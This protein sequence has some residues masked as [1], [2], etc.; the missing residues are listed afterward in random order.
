MD[1]GMGGMAETERERE[2]QCGFY[3]QSVLFDLFLL[4]EI[5]LWMMMMMG[6]KAE[7]SFA[8]T[9][10][11]NGFVVVG[12]SLFLVEGGLKQNGF[13]KGWVYAGGGVEW[14]AE[15]RKIS[16]QVV[17]NIDIF[18]S[19]YEWAIN[20]RCGDAP[21]CGWLWQKVLGSDQGC[22]RD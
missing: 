13:D 21:G 12:R 18:L 10:C 3:R 11:L 2:R 22:R 19:R 16:N 20:K 7:K 15:E 9:W 4:R 17:L 5:V 1:A 14:H 6:G 8:M